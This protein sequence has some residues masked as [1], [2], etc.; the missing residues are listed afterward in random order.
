MNTDSLYAQ[1]AYTRESTIEKVQALARLYRR[2]GLNEA[3]ALRAAT[4]DLKIQRTTEA[5]YEF[6]AAA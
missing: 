2:F 5:R 6:A 3:A 1:R 4:A